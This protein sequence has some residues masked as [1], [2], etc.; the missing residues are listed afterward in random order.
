MHIKSKIVKNTYFEVKIEFLSA[1]SKFPVQNEGNVSTENNE[2]TPYL[3]MRRKSN[4]DCYK[5][6]WFWQIGPLPYTSVFQLDDRG[7]FGA[8]KSF[9]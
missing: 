4:T 6:V 8:P 3:Q 5:N 7:L 9:V 2:G 1:N